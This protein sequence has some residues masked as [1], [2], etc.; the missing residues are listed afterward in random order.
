[1]L[2][3]YA[4][5]SD[6]LNLKPRLPEVARMRENASYMGRF[7]FITGIYGHR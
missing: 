2:F 6:F 4:S 7:A 1:M 3:Y 5:Q